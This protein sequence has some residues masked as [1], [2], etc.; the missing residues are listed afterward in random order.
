MTR[1]RSGFTLIELL[2]VIAIIAVLIGLLLPAVQKVR[3]AAARLKCQNNLKQLAL[4]CHNYESARNR[5]PPGWLGPLEDVP[6][7]S[8][9]AVDVQHVALIAF[10]LPYIEQEPIYRAIQTN[11]DVKSLGN[12]SATPPTGNWWLNANNLTV[13]TAKV[14]ILLCPS[15]DPEDWTTGVGVVNH[16]YNDNS[17]PFGNET[18]TFG[19]GTFADSLGLTSYGGVAGMWANGT[20]AGLPPIL[21]AGQS[22]NTFKGFFYNRSQVSLSK[23]PDGTS[24]TVMLGEALGGAQPAPNG[25]PVYSG[26]WMGFGCL[27]A[28]GGLPTNQPV[29]YQFSSRHTG[30]VNFAFGDGSVHAMSSGASAWTAGLPPPDWIKFQGMAGVRDGRVDDTSVFVS[31]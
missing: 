19:H 25:P 5:L 29:W 3:E 1:R 16:I 10:L 24:N 31:P 14:P 8:G 15:H 12:N 20:N 28:V 23:V 26:S 22:I 2:V 6:P 30:L 7:H 21:P 17:A 13:A 27:P 18:A 4:A 9:N 11:W